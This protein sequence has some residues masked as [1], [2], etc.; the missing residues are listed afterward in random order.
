MRTKILGFI[1]S[2][3]LVLSACTQSKTPD[4]LPRP[5]LPVVALE[6]RIP[7]PDLV[8]VTFVRSE[9]PVELL[10]SGQ[11]IAAITPGAIPAGLEGLTYLAT[12]TVIL[13]GWLDN[14]L[15]LALTDAKD[16]LTTL[17]PPGTAG[18][19]RLAKGRLS[20]LRLGWK[21]VAIDGVLPTVRTI[22]SG[23]YPLVDR[24]SLVWKPNVG[25]STADMLAKSAHATPASQQMI[26][27][28]VVG[29]IMLA[30]GVAA[31]MQR[32][33]RDYPI[34]KVRDHIATA[35]LAFANLE[36][37]IGVTGRPLPGKQIWFRSA[38]E[39]VHLL[40]SLGLDGVTIA[41]NHIMDY[42]TEN[43]LETLEIL[44]RIGLPYVGGGRDV[45]AAR[46]PLVL[47]A[48]GVR[49]AF[50]GYSEFADI[51]WDL[52]YRKSFAAGLER[53]GVAGI[54]DQWLAEDIKLAGAQADLVIATFHWG[55]EFQNYPTSEQRRLAR[56]SIDLGADAVIG[57]HPHAIQGFEIYK[58]GFIAYSTGNF[59]MDRQDTD[60]ARES[61]ILD[62]Y[63]NKDGLKSVVVQPVWIA[64]EQPYIL[65]G[66]AA[67]N[68]MSKMRRISGWQ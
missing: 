45:A 18:P 23:A 39:S 47:E 49:V 11:A 58:E 59:I 34:E 43:F 19:G 14:P 57:Y 35:D 32:H 10:L 25:A 37:P 21:P 24:T 20:D 63:V 22:T 33:G 38:P 4:P 60:L 66:V 3:M 29:D 8:G 52:D 41:N 56:L 30:R 51:Y 53:P 36:S 65:A 61:M 16:R 5:V 27:V 6:T 67:D 31:A 42:D 12:E 44:D 62:L 64:A 15:A 26:R 7:A 1:L 54:H 48:Q 2:V 46:K 55:E 17:G 68:L 28:S 9:A 40:T 13:Q 50:L